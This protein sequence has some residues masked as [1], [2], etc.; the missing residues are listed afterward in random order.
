MRRV[1]SLLLGLLAGLCLT[2]WAALDFSRGLTGRDGGQLF[3]SGVRSNQ[4]MLFE[5]SDY[6][7]LNF[8][9]H[10]ETE[11]GVTSFLDVPTGLY[12]MRMTVISGD[13]AGEPVYRVVCVLPEEPVIVCGRN[14]TVDIHGIDLQYKE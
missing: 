7:S 6:P 4:V 5:F 3:S 1:V 11:P 14:G 13:V 9:Y 2:S 10:Y 8:T 12:R